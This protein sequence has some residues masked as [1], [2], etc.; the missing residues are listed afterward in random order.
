VEREEEGRREKEV[1]LRAPAAAPCRRHAHAPTLGVPHAGGAASP[2]AWVSE[3]AHTGAAGAGCPAAGRWR[4]ATR[5]GPGRALGARGPRWRERPVVAGVWRGRLLQTPPPP[6]PQG[7]ERPPSR[8]IW[9]LGD[10]SRRP[11]TEVGAAETRPP[12]RRRAPTRRPGPQ[13]GVLRSNPCPSCPPR[14]RTPVR[15]GLGGGC[16][17]GC[18]A[19]LYLALFSLRFARPAEGAARGPSVVSLRATACQV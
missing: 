5:G 1:G 7:R 16:A 19:R 9:P 12:T 15:V 13:R 17:R 18:R 3:R 2:A 10:T 14:A 4:C 6:R 8:R 11:Q